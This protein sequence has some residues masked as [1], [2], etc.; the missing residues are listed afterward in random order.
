[1]IELGD[2]VIFDIDGTLA[3]I[4]HR[5]HYV[6]RS[7]IRKGDTVKFLVR[8][9]EDAL[10]ETGFHKL[11]SHRK[12]RVVSG[13]NKMD[14]YQISIDGRVWNVHD[15]LFKKVVNWDAFKVG[16]MK[17][18]PNHPVCEVC[19]AMKTRGSKI[20]LCSGRDESQREQTEAWLREWGILHDAL[21]M[22]PEN[23]FRPDVEI[24]SEALVQIR[25]DGFKPYLVFD[26]RSRLVE[27]WR[28][29]GLV[30]CQVA[31]GNF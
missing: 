1:M 10:E 5:R 6:D 14:L 29:A 21:Y 28:A 9:I 30:C 2:T 22:R 20:V 27:M 15:N 13:P 12:G 16:I 18:T 4:S 3:D 23:D 26:D 31:E 25:Q 8:C 17:D 19:S 24:K 7:D 11:P